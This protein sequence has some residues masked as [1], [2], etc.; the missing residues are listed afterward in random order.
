MHVGTNV[1]AGVL[2]HACM[3]SSQR[4]ILVVDTGSLTEHGSCYL[5]HT[6]TLGVEMIAA[7]DFYMG[8]GEFELRSARMG[9]EH[10]GQQS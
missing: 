8:S 1:F 7:S 5:C 6:G 10:P 2:T 4:P 3:C 9:S